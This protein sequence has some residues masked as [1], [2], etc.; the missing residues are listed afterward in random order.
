MPRVTKS[1]KEELRRR[2]LRAAFAEFG[3]KGYDK[4]SLDDVAKVVGIARGTI[5]LYFKSKKEI[6]E[7]ISAQMLKG[8]RMLLEQHEWTKGDI[9]STARS[10][11]RESK[12]SNPSVSA[13][14]TVEMMAESS[15]NEELRKQRLA[16]NRKMQEIIIDVI[17]SELRRRIR[18]DLEVKEIALGAI[19]LYNGLDMLRILGYRQ[20]E[21]ENAWTRTISM[22][23]RSEVQKLEKNPMNGSRQ[24][25]VN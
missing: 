2:I 5:Y 14:M 7:A 1:Y 21:I 4:T 25:K 19:A 15:R 13:R 12:G 3:R 6:F 22:I 20:K 8:F 23:T 18:N 9:A 10:F 24:R 11:Y 16:E 17:Q